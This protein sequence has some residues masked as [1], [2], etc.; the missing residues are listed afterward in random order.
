[1]CDTFSRI[2]VEQMRFINKHTVHLHGCA[3]AAV[4]VLV[5][6]QI[7]YD[8]TL[9]CAHFREHEGLG[10][11][12]EE[13]IDVNVVPYIDYAHLPDLAPIIQY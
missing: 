7:V 4:G 11:Q 9:L 1:M 8:Y 12:D 10:D 13:W 5:T 2:P 6:G 3:C